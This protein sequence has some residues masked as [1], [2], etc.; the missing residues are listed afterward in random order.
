M[1]ISDN[2]EQVITE[3][4]RLL[5]I[6]KDIP[7]DKLKVAEG[8]II[9]AA[10]L[11]IML[12]YMWKDIQENGEYAMFQQTDKAP[13]YERERP[14]ARL[15]TTRDQSYQRVIKQLT[16]LL[17]KEKKEEEPQKRRTAGDLL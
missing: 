7:S 6:Y 16:D 13:P 12:N 15:Y 5:E 4:E 9:Q 8:L 3:R 11:R 14:V 10:R 2:D 17:P 1:K